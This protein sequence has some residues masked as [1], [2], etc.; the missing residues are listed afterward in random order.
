MLLKAIG[1]A[2]EQA[3]ALLTTMPEVINEFFC[4]FS[5]NSAGR[6]K[7]KCLCSPLSYPTLVTTNSQRLAAP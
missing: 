3:S 4:N 6:E 1:V 5:E 2:S 7:E